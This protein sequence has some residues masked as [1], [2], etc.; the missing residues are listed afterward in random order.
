MKKSVNKCFN[1]FL[2]ILVWCA[3]LTFA[4]PTQ[5]ARG[6]SSV[7]QWVTVTQETALNFVETLPNGQLKWGDF[8]E[9]PHG[10]GQAVNVDKKTGR[11]IFSTEFVC[12]EEGKRVVKRVCFDITAT[13][14]L[15]RDA[16][17]PVCCQIAPRLKQLRQLLSNVK[18]HESANCLAADIEALLPLVSRYTD[19]IPAEIP[20]GICSHIM[21]EH[22]II[23]DLEAICAEAMRLVMERY[24]GSEALDKV[25]RNFGK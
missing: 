18:D 20:Y 21:E 23:A 17:S 14:P 10:W 2:A 13:M 12:N 6:G 4:E 11:I 8:L 19:G 1:K 16:L 9:Y 3:S 24:Y 22:G 7:E 5:E 15:Y 25:M